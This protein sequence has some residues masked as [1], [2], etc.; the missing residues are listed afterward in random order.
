MQDL[1][2]DDKRQTILW[3]D[4]ELTELHFSWKGKLVVSRPP[5]ERSWWGRAHRNDMP[6]LS[7]LEES[8]LRFSEF[9]TKIATKI[10]LAS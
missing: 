7:I 9:A 5:P 2:G 6:I 1:T 4:L 3:F 10:G 8:V